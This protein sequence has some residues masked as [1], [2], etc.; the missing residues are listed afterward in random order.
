MDLLIY[1]SAPRERLLVKV[2]FLAFYH[3]N[4]YIYTCLKFYIIMG[5]KNKKGKLVFASKAPWM[6]AK[7]DTPNSGI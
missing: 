4:R 1:S 3:L 5:D 2:V 6:T 7:K